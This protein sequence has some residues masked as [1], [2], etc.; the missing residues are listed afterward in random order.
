MSNVNKHRHTSGK[1][2]SNKTPSDSSKIKGEKS[3]FL[4]KTK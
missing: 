1:P 4:Y 3:K 2:P